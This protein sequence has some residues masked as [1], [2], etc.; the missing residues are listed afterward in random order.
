[1]PSVTTPCEAAIVP[2]NRSHRGSTK[3]QPM[4]TRIAATP[5][6]SWR[7]AGALPG[8]CRC[9]VSSMAC[10]YLSRLDAL[11]KPLGAEHEDHRHRDVD[12][13]ELRG[14]PGVD[15]E[16]PRDPDDE[17]PDGRRSEEHTSELQSRENLVCRL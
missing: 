12:A 1:M 3:A 15:G 14:R 9:T 8:A 17:R 10:L 7:R 11:E 16:R 4:S 2:T 5:A 6:A 13:E